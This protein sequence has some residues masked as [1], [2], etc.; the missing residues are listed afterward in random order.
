MIKAPL[1]FSVYPPELIDSG[2]II[3]PRG[4][5]LVNIGLGRVDDEIQGMM[6]VNFHTSQ[7]QKRSLEYLQSIF[8]KFGVL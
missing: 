6:N 3:I 4:G 2:M 5:Q 7:I 1:Q 8:L